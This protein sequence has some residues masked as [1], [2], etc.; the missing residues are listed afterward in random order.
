MAPGLNWDIMA[1]DDD[2]D[3]TKP[4]YIVNAS[5]LETEHAKLQLLMEQIAKLEALVQRHKSY[6]VCK[7]GFE[8]C[9]CTG[10]MYENVLAE[11][12]QEF[13]LGFNCCNNGLKKPEAVEHV[14]CNRVSRSRRSRRSRNSYKASCNVAK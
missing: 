6:Q 13:N 1:K 11:M 8:N 5:Q 4:E 7:K 10:C 9:A 3:P 2:Y 14:E 12:Y